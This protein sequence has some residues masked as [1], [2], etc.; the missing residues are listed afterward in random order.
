MT[1]QGDIEY[2]NGTNR[3][4]LAPGTSGQVLTTA[5]AGA[6]PS[7]S[8]PGA[9]VLISNTPVTTASNT[10]DIAIIGTNFYEARGI[11]RNFSG[12]DTVVMRINN[13]TGSVYNSITRG[14]IFDGTPTASNSVGA[15]GTSITLGPAD[16]ASSAEQLAF[17]IRLY[18]QRNDNTVF[19]IKGEITGQDSSAN[20]YYKDIS[21]TWSNAAAATSFR[22]LTSGGATFS[23]NVYLYKYSLS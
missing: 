9:L 4:R 14:F 16:S 6:N 12:D 11:I 22:I 13:D 19:Y 8:N 2:H 10:G 1:T 5:G 21:G 17:T 20:N 7:W 18:P 23:G 3:T 15:G